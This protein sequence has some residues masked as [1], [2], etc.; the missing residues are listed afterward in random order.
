MFMSSYSFGT[1]LPFF[2][3]V[4]VIILS[5]TLI[6]KQ[7]CLPALFFCVAFIYKFNVKRCKSKT[8][9]PRIFIFVT[10]FCIIVRVQNW[11][12]E[13]AYLCLDWSRTHIFITFTGVSPLRPLYQLNLISGF[14]LA[15]WTVSHNKS[16]KYWF[17]VSKQ[18][19]VDLTD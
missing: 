16:V 10:I 9:V 8:S 11:L 18:S 14:Y 19:K 17:Y 13:Y 4:F 12:T 5:S 2:M 15:W 3:L 1:C 7:V 6:C